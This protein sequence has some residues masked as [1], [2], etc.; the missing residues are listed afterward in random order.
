MSAYVKCQVEPDG[1]NPDQRALICG[2]LSKY[3]C[4]REAILYG[5]RATGRFRQGSDIDLSLKGDIDSRILNTIN[6]DL[7]DLMLPYIIDLS[8]WQ[9]IDNDALKAHIERVGKVFYRA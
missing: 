5:S 3:P 2:V 4:V 7:D 9:D 8:V 1:L 6:V